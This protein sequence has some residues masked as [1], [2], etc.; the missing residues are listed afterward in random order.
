MIDVFTHVPIQGLEYPGDARM[1]PEGR[2]YVTPEGKKYPSAST[3]VKKISEDA[4]LAWK[5]KVG[6]EQANAIAKRAA[7]RG[8]KLHTVCEHY[9]K[10]N[11]TP[12]DL[13]GMPIPTKALFLQLRPHLKSITGIYC[14]EQALYSHLLRVAGRTDAI[15]LWNGVPSVL[16]FKTTSKAKPEAWLLNY[17]IQLTAY[18]IMFQERTGMKVPQLVLLTATEDEPHAQ[19]IV[20]PTRDYYM[21]L[22]N[23]IREFWSTTPSFA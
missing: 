22:K 5:K 12:M 17:F 19:V 7:D 16:D 21:P 15:V 13:M 8:T 14:I 3:L 9:L 11:M 1:S 10:N 6:E 20:K 23:L 4:I 18:S 2:Y